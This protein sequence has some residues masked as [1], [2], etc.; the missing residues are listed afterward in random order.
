MALHR[1]LEDVGLEDEL[2]HLALQALDLLLLQR[3][4]VAGPGTQ[5]VLRRQQEAV[6][7]FLE[8]GDRQVM[9]S[10]GSRNRGLALEDAKEQGR[11]SLCRSPLDV[12]RQ[13]VD[14]HVFLLAFGDSTRTSYGWLQIPEGQDS[15]S[16]SGAGYVVRP[17]VERHGGLPAL[18]DSNRMF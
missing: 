2:A 7:P 16:L 4:L 3:L 17:L 10:S 5:R 9:L 14:R 12:V 13:L 1:L 15:F 8:L 6:S 18:G 11:A